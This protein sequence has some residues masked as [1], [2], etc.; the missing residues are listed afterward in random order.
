MSVNQSLTES[1]RYRSLKIVSKQ[2]RTCWPK[3]KLGAIPHQSGHGTF[4]KI[5][6]Q[7][8]MRYQVTVTANSLIFLNEFKQIKNFEHSVRL[9]IVWLINLNKITKHR[10]WSS[11]K[12]M[13]SFGKWWKWKISLMSFI[14]YVY[15][16]VWVLKVLWIFLSVTITFLRKLHKTT[17]FGMSPKILPL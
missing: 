14:Y 13:Y 12:P 4:F 16:I 5:I 11:L 7:T 3:F 6:F 15:R 17:I 2:F 8:Q 1:S 10:K 9:T